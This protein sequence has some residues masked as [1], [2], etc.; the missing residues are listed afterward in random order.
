L[1][2]ANNGIGWVSAGHTTLYLKVSGLGW[3]YYAPLR[4]YEGG[5]AGCRLREK[6]TQT[7]MFV[8]FFTFQPTATLWAAPPPLSR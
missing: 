3:A 7:W 5:E 2:I 6:K 1:G 4:Q 8:F